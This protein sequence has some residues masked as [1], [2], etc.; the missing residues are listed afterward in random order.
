MALQ[1]DLEGL[2]RWPGITQLSPEMPRSFDKKLKLW[3][4]SVRKL[5]DQIDSYQAVA[6]HI[7]DEGLRLAPKR[8]HLIHGL[9]AIAGAEDGAW[10]VQSYKNAGKAGYQIERSTVDAGRLEGTS[11]AILKL[12]GDIAGFMASRML[13]QHEG[14][15]QVSR[16]P[17]G[18]HQAHPSPPSSAKP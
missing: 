9:W 7:R 12:G 16:A 3:R 11:A 2:R 15:L 10:V 5:F 6:D 13:H 18:E 17:S 14:L 8:N 1:V 4:R